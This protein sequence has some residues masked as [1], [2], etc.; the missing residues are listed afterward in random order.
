MP[1]HLVFQPKRIIEAMNRYL[2][3]I[4]FTLIAISAC[5]KPKD[6]KVQTFR[7][8][9]PNTE[10]VPEN[11]ASNSENE[12]QSFGDK[13][14]RKEKQGK[15]SRRIE[16]ED[17][18]GLELP[19]KLKDRSE[20]MLKKQGFAVSYNNKYNCPNYVAWHLNS[21]RLKGNAHRTK[22]EED[23]R[24]AKSNRVQWYDYDGS[25]Y[26]RGHMC[27][28]AD[29]KW[30]QDATNETFL[31][32]NICPQSH[33]LNEGVWNDLE[34]KCRSWAWRGKDLYI[35]CG[36]IFDN[37]H[38]K[39]IGK[40]QKVRIAVPDRF[41]KVVLSAS[42]EVTAIGFIY[43]NSSTN[44][45]MS[46]YCVSVDSIEAITGIDFYHILDDELE[47]I[48]EAECNPRKWGIQ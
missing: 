34:Q 40:S 47:D 32:S 35:V 41:F 13:K 18:Q 37:K 36:P 5:K 42:D 14:P 22:F 46:D 28:A 30:N 44:L 31:M 23:P 29:N 39:T 10:M 45:P 21:K 1:F 25:G 12:H 4:L 19:A 33:N 26:D 3:F 7:Y 20:N 48:I 38:P 8:S 15:V 9:N 43:P 17:R 6:E 24:V 27:P 2:L 16:E 11:A